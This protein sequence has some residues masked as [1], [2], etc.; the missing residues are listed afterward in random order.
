M[1]QPAWNSPQDAALPAEAFFAEAESTADADSS[2]SLPSSKERRASDSPDERAAGSLAPA[3]MSSSSSTTLSEANGSTGGTPGGT[4]GGT[5]LT[6]RPLVSYDLERIREILYRETGIRIDAKKDYFL[7]ARIQ[8]RM[9]ATGCTRFRQYLT[10]LTGPRRAEEMPSLIESVTINESYFFRDFEQLRGFGEE[11]LP[12]YCRQKIAHA[13]RYLRVW[14]AGC[15]TGEEAYT[16]SIILREMLDDYPSWDT[17]IEATD[18]DRNVLEKARVGVFSDWT[19]RGTPHPYREKYFRQLAEGWKVLPTV[20]APIHFE[21]SNLADPVPI[22]RRRKF[23]FIFCRNVLIYF[24][25]ESRRRVVDFFHRML[26][27]GGYL[28]LGH[29]ESVARINSSFI[30]ERVG[31]HFCYRRAEG[32][33][34]GR[35]SPW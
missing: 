11:V 4:V 15:S 13:N 3:V 26:E 20:R 5:G 23:D 31:D 17:L 9:E 32:A 22:Q 25:N 8:Q 7:E 21:Y 27:P 33:G 1:K 30:P 24:D 18:I 2:S 34:E 29:A 14:S 6:I 35:K 16:L 10:L 12:R 28:F 19:M